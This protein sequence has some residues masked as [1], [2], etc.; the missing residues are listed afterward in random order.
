[1]RIK[2]L[3]KLPVRFVLMVFPLLTFM[4]AEPAEAQ[5]L[6]AQGYEYVVQRCTHTSVG[7]IACAGYALDLYNGENRLVVCTAT[8]TYQ[9]GTSGQMRT[10]STR[11]GVYP[12]RTE[13]VGVTGY[14]LGSSLRWRLERC[15]Y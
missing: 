1:M 2:I 4:G 13:T 3:Q 9:D 7:W 15:T 14:V 11:Q 8:F 10:S 5:Q 12:G 6:D